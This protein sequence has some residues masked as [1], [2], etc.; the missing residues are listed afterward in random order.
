ME[1]KKPFLHRS[2]ELLGKKYSFLK[3]L[4]LIASIILFSLLFRH[5]DVI[6]GWLFC[7]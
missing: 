7:R 5:W 6:I 1:R 3:V 4:V 2:Y